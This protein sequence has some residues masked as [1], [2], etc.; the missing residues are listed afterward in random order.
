MVAYSTTLWRLE[1]AFSLQRRT[2]SKFLTWA[3]I[4]SEAER[5]VD[6]AARRRTEL[7]LSEYKSVASYRKHHNYGLSM[8]DHNA[9]TRAA[10]REAARRG[11]RLVRSM[12][13]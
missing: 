12:V 6:A 4:Q 2:K 9:I 3:Q 10:M 11:L 1:V 13:D 7:Y 8:S 5:L